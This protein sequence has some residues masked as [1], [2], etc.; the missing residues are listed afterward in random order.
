MSGLTFSILILV[1]LVVT[2]IAGSGLARRMLMVLTGFAALA[3]F[4]IWL[5]MPYSPA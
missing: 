4:V 3:V 1:L 5:F 2:S